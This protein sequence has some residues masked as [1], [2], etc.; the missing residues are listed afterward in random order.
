M[1]TKRII[2]WADLWDIVSYTAIGG[3]VVFALWQ[4]FQ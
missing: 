1:T 3:I 4:S 2:R